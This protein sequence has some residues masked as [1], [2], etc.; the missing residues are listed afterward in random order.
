[1]SSS[2]IN[3]LIKK[4]PPSKLKK[5]R[6]AYNFFCADMRPVAKLQRGVNVASLLGK[7]WKELKSDKNRT[8]E[9]KKYTDLAAKDKLRYESA[10]QSVDLFDTDLFGPK[11]VQKRS[12]TAY[13]FFS[14]KN[15]E[16]VKKTLGKKSKASEITARLKKMWES[17]SDDNM[18][19]YKK[20]A[21]DDKIIQAKESLKPDMGIL[22]CIKNDLSYGVFPPFQFIESFVFTLLWQ[23]YV[24]EDKKKFADDLRAASGKEKLILQ[25]LISISKY[26]TEKERLDIFRSSLVKSKGDCVVCYN[27]GDVFEWP[28]HESHITCE[29]C[30]VA[31]TAHTSFCPLCRFQMKNTSTSHYLNELQSSAERFLR[32]TEEQ[33][34]TLDDMRVFEENAFESVNSIESLNSIDRFIAIYLAEFSVDE[35]RTSM[36]S[37]LHSQEIFTMERMNRVYTLSLSD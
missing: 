32:S 34:L 8:E 12:K 16:E 30:M 11:P 2:H 9:M 35:L 17:L 18:I 24:F 5:G 22:N 25:I 20:L 31:I 36:I 13:Q 14:I 6:T 21:D 23:I 15:R 4:P 37:S 28:C 29:D 3:I 1:M 19:E 26:I 7:M 33:I 27:N 10:V